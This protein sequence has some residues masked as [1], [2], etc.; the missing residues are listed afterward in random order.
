MQTTKATADRQMPGRKKSL[1][2]RFPGSSIIE[3]AGIA[4]GVQ[5]ATDEATSTAI[6]TARGSAPSV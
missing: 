2:R 6:T 3:F 1:N 5:T 4:S